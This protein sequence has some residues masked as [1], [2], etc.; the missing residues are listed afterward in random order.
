[1][2]SEETISDERS[3]GASPAG[4]RDL[5]IPPPGTMGP[6]VEYESLRRECPVARVRTLVGATAW[7][8]TR[9]QDVGSVLGDPR[10]VR[11]NVDDWPPPEG[12]PVSGCHRLVMMMELEGPGHRALRRSLA[13]AFSPA[14]MREREPRVR[15]L[16]EGLLDEFERH[17]GP[18]DL[19]GGFVEP[20]P[21]LVMCDLVG[22]PYAQQDYFVPL[23]DSALTAMVD[24]VEGRRVSAPLYE[25][26]DGLIARKRREPGDD[27]LSDLL[28]R[29]DAGELSADDVTSFGLTMLLAGFRTTTMFLANSVV[30]LLTS[31]EHLAQLRGNPGLLADAVEELLR[32]LPVLNGVV[33]LQATE[34]ISL[35]DQTI[36]AGDAVLPT[37]PAANRDGSVFPDADTLDF[38]RT[39]NPHLTFGRGRH[40]CLGAHLARL[41]L[42]VALAALLTRFPDLRL[43]VA[44]HE[45]PWEDE[46]PA[47]S[48]L[49][50][51][52]RW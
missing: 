26:V 29:Q 22:I 50:L 34:E 37:I 51:P 42:R 32:F 45:L 43:T 5:P 27:V 18:A 20:F 38:A 17:S 28:R 9:Y 2:T 47:K 46:S 3:R 10:F 21:L 48:P 19:L 31:P 24:V 41:T 6:P 49:A 14:A 39:R 4:A 11:P 7:Y 30:T 15:A 35:L 1:M 23:V 36:R 52:V 12:N 8:L 13:D 25:Y 44:P 40:F 33:V 16:A